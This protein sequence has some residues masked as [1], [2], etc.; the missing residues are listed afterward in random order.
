MYF[1]KQKHETIFY[2][3]YKKID[4]LNFKEALNRELMKHDSNNI[5]PCTQMAIRFSREMKIESKNYNIAIFIYS[6][7]EKKTFNTNVL[8]FI[9]FHSNYEK[10]KC[11]IPF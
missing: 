5:N 3:N 9:L 1:T 8:L 2:R 7:I 10:I 11:E 6:K 4:N